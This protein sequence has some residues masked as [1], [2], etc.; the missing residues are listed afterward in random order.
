MHT[1][2]DVIERSLLCALINEGLHIIQEKVALRAS[3]I[4][5]IYVHGYGFPVYHG[6]PM[7]YAD[8]LGLELVK[9]QLEK[10]AQACPEQWSISPLLEQ[11]ISAGKK[12]HKLQS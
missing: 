6:G 12:L 2:Q 10:C 3:D 7:F 1:I 5:T 9:E 4:D 8:Q 11:C